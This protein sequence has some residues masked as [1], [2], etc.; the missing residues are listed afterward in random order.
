[1]I[2]RK[3][4]IPTFDSLGYSF[5]EENEK[6]GRVEKKEV[7]KKNNKK[8]EKKSSGNYSEYAYK[9]FVKI[10]LI[11]LSI[12]LFLIPISL[13]PLEWNMFEYGRVFVLIVFVILLLA[14]EFIKFFMVGR[15]EFYK[16]PKDIILLILGF[17]FLISYLFSSDALISFWGYEFR[18]GTG[19]LSILAI[20]TYVLILKSVVKDLS[21]ILLPMFFLV[22]GLFTSSF[23]SILS[24][25]N[26]NPFGMLPGFDQ[27]F[28]VGL[29][30]FN[31]AKLSIAIWSGG[32]LLSLLMFFHYFQL[33]NSSESFLNK[34]L[35]LSKAYRKRRMIQSALFFTLFVFVFS[36]SFSI[37]LF[38]LKNLFW[39]G[40]VSIVGIFLI[41]LI[42]NFLSASKALKYASVLIVLV[43]FGIFA[44]LRIP[45]V[46]NVLSIDS[47]NMVE[48]ITLENEDIWTITVSSLSESF[49][50]SLVGLGNDNFV[51]A[52]DLYRPAF[53]GDIDLNLVNYSYANNEVYNIVANRGVV[54]LFVWILVGALLT[55]QFVQYLGDEKR[56]QVLDPN[57]TET[58]GI[59]I[60]D[61]L[62][63]FVWL[64]SFF[65]YYSFILYFMF[66]LILALSSLM[67]NVAYKMHSESVVI[68]T[69]FFV[70]KIGLVKNESLPKVLIFLISILSIFAFYVAT[71][72]F[73][74]RVDAVRAES[75]LLDLE[76][77]QDF[78]DAIAYYDRAILKNPKNYVFRRK[79]AVVLMENVNNV[80]VPEFANLTEDGQ[81]QEFVR[82]V[83]AY[84]EASKEEAK[85]ATEL[86]P[87]I[88]QNWNAKDL[89]YSDLVRMGFHN[90][91][92]A[93][94]EVS[95]QVI[96]L[97]PKNYNAYVNKAT[98]HY[99]L[100]DGGSAIT[101]VRKALEI[102]SYHIQALVLA[103]EISLGLEDLDSAKMYFE[104]SARLLQNLDLNR[105][106]V[107]NLFEN[108]QRNLEYLWSLEVGQESF[109]VEIE[110]KETQEE[111]E[112]IL[113][114][115]EISD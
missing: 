89:I 102:N 91:I 2:D 84:A 58:V 9:L 45:V 57:S 44:F 49:S 115:E 85:K 107:R 8:V 20:L 111:E 41:L 98:Y 77:E 101:Q 16:S 112:L 42:V 22:L 113:P 80:L 88:A 29:P 100:G 21:C 51:V 11:L 69:N 96:L 50:R 87:T 59:L 15:M 17:S 106:E 33:F 63:I 64:V 32:I 5:K 14:F 10:Q 52:Y 26:I 55:K 95:D 103:G 93:A 76:G 37:T 66:F 35:S 60:L 114:D 18:F 109:E 30:L 104:N 53:S 61:L 78:Y 39:I 75:I 65:T 19:F 72:D 1:M 4:K 90:Y 68:Q 54:G 97:S 38:S 74:S 81:R 24:F 92:S 108:I 71:N 83:G 25:Y 40:L 27:F 79:V 94:M 23:L 62:L 46:Q 12:P 82:I 73:S 48:Q 36:F 99:I 67:K 7:E 47:E 110:E 28:F 86:A 13:F 6:R 3:V 34:K 56:K 70:E 105:P 31:S 43:S